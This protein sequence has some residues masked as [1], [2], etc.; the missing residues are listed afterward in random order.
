MFTSNFRDDTANPGAS[1]KVDLLYCR[2]GHK[3]ADGG[4]CILGRVKDEI[5]SSVW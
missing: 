4:A 3:G 1:G 2:M 5:Q